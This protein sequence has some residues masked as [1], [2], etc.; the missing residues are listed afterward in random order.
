MSASAKRS[1]LIDPCRRNSQR[2]G[3]L[4]NLSSFPQLS[5]SDA[6][7]FNLIPKG[8]IFVVLK[9]YFDGGNQ[10]DSSQYKELVLP[11]I[12]GTEPQWKR[13]GK[14]WATAL[15]GKC[16]FIHTTDMLDFKR[17]FSR[18]KGWNQSRRDRILLRCVRVAGKA[19]ARQ[20]DRP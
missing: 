17:E 6:S 12:S 7:A 1:E 3:E 20:K 15:D 9:S 13:F 14:E 5:L 18:A 16:E 11:S 10:A 8:H 4:V 2:K 19:F